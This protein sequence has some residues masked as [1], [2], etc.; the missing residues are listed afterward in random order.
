MRTTAAAVEVAAA[1]ASSQS[2]LPPPVRD[3]ATS[4]MSLTAAVRPASGPA[5][6]PFRG[7]V[8][9]WGTKA[10]SDRATDM[11]ASLSALALLGEIPIE[12]L[13]TVPSDHAIS[14]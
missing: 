1:C 6:A 13:G 9:S 5:P 2:G 11:P 12:N 4:Y 8:K 10:A 7:A 14:T 3:P